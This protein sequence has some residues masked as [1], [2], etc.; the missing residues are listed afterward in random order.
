MELKPLPVGLR[1]FTTWN[2]KCQIGLTMLDL[3]EHVSLLGRR[4]SS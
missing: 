3:P 4:A 2:I 1:V